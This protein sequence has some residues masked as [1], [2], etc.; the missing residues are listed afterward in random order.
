MK[1]RTEFKRAL[2][3]MASFER[4]YKDAAIMY[5]ICPSEELQEDKYL[6]MNKAINK[7]D[8]ILADIKELLENQS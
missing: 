2:E 3:Q 7:R 4:L 1:T 5:M 8:E 6:W